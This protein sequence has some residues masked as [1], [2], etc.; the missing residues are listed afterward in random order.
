MINLYRQFVSKFLA[1]ICVAGL[2][3]VARS[4]SQRPSQGSHS[5][6]EVAARHGILIGTAADPQYL[7]DPNYAAILGSEFTQLQGENQMKFG[8]IH[9]RPDTD[10]NPYDFG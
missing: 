10:P 3:I 5:L 8:L 4:Q 1:L 6:G 7:S 9:P 2:A